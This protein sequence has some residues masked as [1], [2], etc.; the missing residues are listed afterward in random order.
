MLFD[1]TTGKPIRQASDDSKPAG[2]MVSPSISPGSE[3]GESTGGSD[4]PLDDFPIDFNAR[5]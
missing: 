2:P 4:G 5:R 1:A 3:S